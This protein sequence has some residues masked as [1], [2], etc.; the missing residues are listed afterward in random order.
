MPKTQ[1][2]MS[3]SEPPPLRPLSPLLQY[4]TALYCTKFKVNLVGEIADER[5]KLGLRKEGESDGRPLLSE[6][7]FVEF[8]EVVQSQHRRR[9]LNFSNVGTQVWSF[10]DS[11]HLKIIII[12]Y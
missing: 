4:P 5:A 2:D 3:A 9:F 12:H 11:S 6:N 7:L 1:T 10:L 8:V